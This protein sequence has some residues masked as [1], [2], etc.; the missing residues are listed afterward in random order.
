MRKTLVV[1]NWKMH[2]NTSEASILIHRLQ[3]RIPI[4]RD[5]EVVL[6]PTSLVLQPLSMQI[7]R[8]KFRLAAQN[9]FYMD[10]G[11]FT[12]EISF[13]MLRE[14]VHYV[15]VG[16][17]ERRY[18]FEE[19]DKEVSLKMAAALR[20]GISPIL[21]IGETNSE[22][23]AGETNQVI[24]DQLLVGLSHVGKEEIKNTVITYEPVWAVSDGTDYLNHRMPTPTDVLSVVAKIRH[25]IKEAYG[26]SA[27]SAV[28]VLY[29]GSIN[30][31]NA[32]AF[33]DVDGVDGLLVGGASLN[34]QQF[35]DIVE[36][37]YKYTSTE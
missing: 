17:S 21:C 14:L 9:A 6:A 18:K 19:G 5:V 4:R 24:H 31:E 25:N 10:E 22:R 8:R 36:A 37:A 1:G 7:D 2:L 27:E 30:P 32:R 23:L 20:N 11:A 33:L 3:E 12:G 13:N 29:G 28:R 15:I 35:S 26:A 34:Y 16:H